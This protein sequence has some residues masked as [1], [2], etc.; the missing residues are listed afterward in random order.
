MKRGVATLFVIAAMTGFVVWVPTTKNAG[1]ALPVVHAQDQSS[2]CSLASVNGSYAVERQGTV[3]AQLPGL[4][5]PP[6]PL[7]AVAVARVNGAGSLF[8]SSTV[9]IGGAVLNAV[10]FTGTYTVQSDCTGTVTLDVPSVGLT[11]HEAIVVIGGGQRFIGTETD[12]F[13]VVQVRGQKLAD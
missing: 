11:I 12:P 13:Q 10:P 7:V 2:G 5:A 3:I 9:N 8:G 1:A 6:A 4:P